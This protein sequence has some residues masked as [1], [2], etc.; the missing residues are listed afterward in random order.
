MK[1]WV[2]SG[3]GGRTGGS[4]AFPCGY[5]DGGFLYFRVAAAG[6]RIR[7][8]AMARRSVGTTVFGGMIV[9]TAFGIF[10][11]PMLFVTFIKR[12]EKFHAKRHSKLEE[13]TPVPSGQEEG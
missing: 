6:Y 7:G 3:S 4:S 1:R 5:D 12:R 9:A 8:G 13:R 11:I 10:V 2:G